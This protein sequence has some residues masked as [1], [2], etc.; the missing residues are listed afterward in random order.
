MLRPLVAGTAV[1]FILAPV[2]SWSKDPP[3]QTEVER[4]GMSFSP[5]RSIPT[6]PRSASSS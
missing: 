3:Q 4:T 2:A 6:A 1:A 5:S